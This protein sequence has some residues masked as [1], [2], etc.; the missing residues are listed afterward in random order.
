MP[1]VTMKIETA[2]EEERGKGDGWMDPE[3][4]RELGRNGERDSVFR[5]P[6]W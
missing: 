1:D 4:T 3:F 2:S 6:K 5:S